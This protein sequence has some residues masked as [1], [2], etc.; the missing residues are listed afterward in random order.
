MDTQQT[1]SL[2]PAALE[3]RVAAF[4]NRPASPDDLAMLR[5]AVSCVDL[6]SLDGRETPEK[7]NTLCSTACRP[8]EGAGPTAAVCVYPSFVA[9]A[10][11]ALGAASP[12]RLASVV[13][14]PTGQEPLELKLHQAR[15]AMADGANEIDMVLNRQAFLAGEH[16]RAREEVA[17]MVRLCGS[18]ARVKVILETGELGSPAN[19]RAAALLALG[20]LRQGDFIKTSTGKV[21]VNAT[22]ESHQVMLEAIRDHHRATGVAV[23]IKPAGGI[24]SSQDALGYLAAVKATLGSAWLT[25]ERYRFGA[26]SLLNDL[27]LRIKSQTAPVHELG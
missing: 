16:A 13:G 20:A 11:K 5:L 18:R 14:F 26:S 22:L 4:R 1:P 25:P 19:I 10:R 9:Q 15:N 21:P 3:A 7:I 23:G 17:A 6:T 27:L 2:A 8:A 12:V 24:K